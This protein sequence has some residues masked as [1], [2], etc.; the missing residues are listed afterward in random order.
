[1]EDSLSSGQPHIPCM[2]MFT[3]CPLLTPRFCWLDSHDFINKT[4]QPHI[5]EV[6]RVGNT[7]PCQGKELTVVF[8]KMLEIHETSLGWS[9]NCNACTLPMFWWFVEYYGPFKR[10]FSLWILDEKTYSSFSGTYDIRHFD[11][12]FGYS[13]V[14]G[15]K[16]RLLGQAMLGDAAPYRQAG[17]GRSQVIASIVWTPHTI[18]IHSTNFP[19]TGHR[20]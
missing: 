20:I 11:R 9:D 1:M 12:D 13:G 14:N 2:Y 3:I 6:F 15:W 5:L 16:L 8:V 17:G 7:G 18:T 4:H 10:N 19:T